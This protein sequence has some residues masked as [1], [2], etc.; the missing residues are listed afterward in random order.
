MDSRR[1][2][3]GLRS[4]HHHV[5]SALGKKLS[6][7]SRSRKAASLASTPSNS[8]HGMQDEQSS[9]SDELPSPTGSAF[10][11]SQEEVDGTAR[12]MSVDEKEMSTVRMSSPPT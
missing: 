8:D 4:L 6:F 2:H 5:K 12:T 11:E 9:S 3:R 10:T 1:I 7:R